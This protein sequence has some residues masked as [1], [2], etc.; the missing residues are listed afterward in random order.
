MGLVKFSD[1]WYAWYN[2][3]MQHEDSDGD[4]QSCDDDR[5]DADGEYL[6]EIEQDGVRGGTQEMADVVA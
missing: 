3:R 1:E 5:D 2:A 6:A 4:Q